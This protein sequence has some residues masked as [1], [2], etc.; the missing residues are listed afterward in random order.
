MGKKTQG[1]GVNLKFCPKIEGKKLSGANFYKGLG[2][3]DI[4]IT[5]VLD[6]LANIA[7]FF[8]EKLKRCNLTR[9]LKDLQKNSRCAKKLN[10]SKSSDSVRLQKVA[11]KKPDLK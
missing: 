1:I 9:N 7:I 4:F 2:F 10:P 3:F 6:L 5:K 8:K 11:Q